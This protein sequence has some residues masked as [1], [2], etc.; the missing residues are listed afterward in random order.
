VTEEA[1]FRTWISG[2]FVISAIGDDP[3]RPLAFKSQSDAFRACIVHI[4]AIDSLIVGKTLAN[5]SVT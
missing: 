5:K 2:D 1:P 3:P 4:A